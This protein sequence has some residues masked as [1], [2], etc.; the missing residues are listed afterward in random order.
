MYMPAKETVIMSFA[1]LRDLANL[2]FPREDYYGEWYGQECLSCNP[3]WHKFRRL[4]ISD[5][6]D[7]HIKINKE[8]H[9]KDKVFFYSDVDIYADLRK[10]IEAR[11]KDG[12]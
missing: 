3:R 1:Q 2:K 7:G 9:S 4:A 10:K 8:W 12:K 11:V 5:R 6:C